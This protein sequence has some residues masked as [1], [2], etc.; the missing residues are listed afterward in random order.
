MPLSAAILRRFPARVFVETGSYL[1]DGARAALDAGFGRV[2]T[3]E[4]GR[5]SWEHVRAR[6]ADDPRVTA[7][8]GDSAELLA[9]AIADVREPMVFWLDAHWS[10]EGTGGRKLP[11]YNRVYSPVLEEL[12]AVAAHPVRGHT[13]LVD[14]VRVFRDGVFVDADEEPIP[15]VRL[16]DAVLDVDPR[17]Q[18]ELLDGAETGDVLA[19]WVP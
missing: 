17:Y 2:V 8:L 7:I 3:L 14:D 4:A 1:G 6:F 18:L 16:M 9:A 13:I 12:A 11:G 5:A 10:G 15:L 19:A